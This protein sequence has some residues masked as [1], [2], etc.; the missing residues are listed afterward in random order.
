MGSDVG[1][2]N[3]PVFIL[4]DQNFPPMAPAGGGGEC[5]KIIQVENGTLM[6]LVEVFL[7]LSRGFDMRLV[8]LC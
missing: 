6:D 5:L 4:S 1:M 3:P 8:R 2:D 7:G